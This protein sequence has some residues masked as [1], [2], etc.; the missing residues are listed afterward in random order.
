MRIYALPTDILVGLLADTRGSAY[1]YGG[2]PGG[3]RSGVRSS[4]R[5][6]PCR[7]PT[8]A[9]PPQDGTTRHYYN[10]PP[11]LRIVLVQ[12]TAQVEAVG[13]VP[14]PFGIEIPPYAVDL[15][16][17]A[18]RRIVEIRIQKRVALTD[19]QLPKRTL[20]EDQVLT[21][22]IPSHEPHFQDIL[23]LAQYIESIGS[24]H[25]GIRHIHWSNA[26]YD[27]VPE[28]EEE[29]RSLQVFSSNTTLTYPETPVPVTPE[30]LYRLVRSRERLDHL[31]I[32]MA[33]FREGVNDYRA[34]R[35]VD[36]FRNHYYFLEGLFGG[37][38]TKNRQVEE[39]FHSS[40]ILLKAVDQTLKEFSEPRLSRHQRSLDQFFRREGTAWN[41][42]GVI[43]FL[44]GM[45]GNLL[46]FS[47]GSS[48]PKG[49]P[50]NQ[51]EFE[52]VAFLI[53]RI[54]YRVVTTIAN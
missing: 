30:V 3:A 6:A 7:A 9:G 12:L 4:L 50:L 40:P 19:I 27:W 29:R 41:T 1:V 48:K 42:E 16:C 20:S 26:K 44:V 2:W 51:R 47:Q 11:C 34:F 14:E 36:A 21:F 10:L 49:H 8:C 22:S 17:D 15:G 39:K 31:K 32:P 53:L 33:F 13:I 52:S 28:T 23:D 18:N 35:Y 24:F 46:H 37:T 5:W 43:K 45:R 25:L 54:C 38:K